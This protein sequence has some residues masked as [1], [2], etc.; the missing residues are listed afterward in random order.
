MLGWMPNVLKHI[1][2]LKQTVTKW[3]PARW[4]PS[5]QQVVTKWSPSGQQVAVKRWIFNS[6]SMPNAKVCFGGLR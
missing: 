5:G 2:Q 6:F 4:S 3:S 1:L